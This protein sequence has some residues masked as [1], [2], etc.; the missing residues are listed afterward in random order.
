MGDHIFPWVVTYERCNETWEER[1][2]QPRYIGPFDIL[3]RVCAV[4]YHLALPYELSMIHTVF[5]ASML[6][7]YLP[8]LLHVFTSHN[9]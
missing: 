3:D 8:D 1:Q 9:I 7:K 4:A 5:H 6:R 2:A